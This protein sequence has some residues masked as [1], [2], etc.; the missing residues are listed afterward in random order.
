MH[1][2]RNTAAV[3]YD[4]YRPVNIDSHRNVITVASQCL[5]YGVINDLVN[6]VV[7]SLDGG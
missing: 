2:C 6:K 7:Q 1:I 5:V 3:I 4:G